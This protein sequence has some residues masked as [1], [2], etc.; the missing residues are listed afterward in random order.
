MAPPLGNLYL[1]LDLDPAVTD[2]KPITD[3][4]ERKQAVWSKAHDDRSKNL[5]LRISEMRTALLDANQ[6][7][8]YQ[9]YARAE[10]T[11]L[12][13]LARDRLAAL[14]DTLARSMREGA[15]VIPAE[16]SRLADAV[17]PI[18]LADV[19]SAL[20]AAGL[21]VLEP[22]QQS[23]RKVNFERIDDLLDQ[24]GKRDLYDMLA[25]PPTASLTEMIAKADAEFARVDPKPAKNV[26]KLLVQK[27]VGEAKVIFKTEVD[28]NIYDAYLA[29]ASLRPLDVHIELL[30]RRER[31][32][33]ADQLALLKACATKMGC[34]PRV[35][36]TYI[37]RYCESKNFL[38][39]AH[40]SATRRGQPLQIFC[41][42]CGTQARTPD[43][44]YCWQCGQALS[45][46]CFACN[47]SVY[48]MDLACVT[49][50]FVIADAAPF[51]VKF[52]AARAASSAGE[53]E[54]ATQLLRELLTRWPHNERAL[55]ALA[56]ATTRTQQ[57]AAARINI[58]SAIA[59]R[60]MLAADKALLAAVASFGAKAFEAQRAQVH[61]ALALAA[62]SLGRAREALNRGQINEAEAQINAALQAVADDTDAQTLL[63]S[64][65]VDAPR[66]LKAARQ[67]VQ[68]RLHWDAGVS[69]T[70]YRVLRCVGIPATPE[71]SMTV[72][73]LTG[74]EW[75]D[76]SPPRGISLHYAIVALRRGINSALA[77]AGPVLVPDT[78]TQ[79][80]AV[81]GDGQVQLSWRLPRGATNVELRATPQSGSEQRWQLGGDGFVHDELRNG[82]QVDYTLVAIF[83]D[84]A[85]VSCLS[86]P[87]RTNA[88]PS[89]ALEP[90]RSLTASREGTSVVFTWQP[91]PSG[92]T[93][94]R[95][96]NGPLHHAVGARVSAG[97]LATLGSVLSLQLSSSG[98]GCAEL[99][100]IK[101]ERIN[102]VAVTMGALSATIGASTSLLILDP[103]R[104]ATTSVS[105]RYIVV[106]W[107]WP[108]MG[109]HVDVAWRLD[110]APECPTDPR[111]IV[112]SV[113]REEYAR[114]GAFRIHAEVE[115][116]HHIALWVRGKEGGCWS[117]G[118]ILRES[119]GVTVEVSYRVGRRLFSSE[120][121]VELKGPPGTVLSNLEIR[122]HDSKVPNKRADGVMIAQ[123]ATVQLT[124]GKARIKVL[125][126][127]DCHFI[128]VF[129]DDPTTYRLLS[130]NKSGERI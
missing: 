130:V 100:S 31:C 63:D 81:P 20:K 54:R 111:A 76:S 105:G 99:G 22:G 7:E 30:G 123:A 114:N 106:K 126:D 9:A 72:A 13:K 79:F 74:T 87:V 50:G 124:G 53:F 19:R 84:P 17:K 62:G 6:R 122:A 117:D 71:D 8:V 77:T 34:N 27:L 10:Q 70:R 91:P 4:I 38:V 12:I 85:G 65:P 92:S 40:I 42:H 60:Q 103:V 89:I 94:I 66:Q 86:A 113:S 47:Q 52:S 2:T 49:C 118:V 97:E 64:I 43:E 59:R 125:N 15:V 119:M 11:R 57:A 68:V 36:E 82:E 29:D 23:T 120:R 35:A 93:E 128:K 51:E 104:E 55:E 73:E 121:Y 37:L 67:G 16:L 33:T 21:R 32:I 3:A 14:V 69:G 102:F 88:T 24:L 26:E 108:A 28:R 112:Q 41:A 116:V 78:P 75:I 5:L 46:K 107:N 83:P 127:Y 44:I 39:Y 101:S 80:V 109:G 96:L 129:C 1:L 90:V 56:V 115:Q 18:S 48:A 25:L 98:M 110:R 58:E 45:G 61:A 95:Q